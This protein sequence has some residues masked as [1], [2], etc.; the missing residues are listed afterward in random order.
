MAAVVRAVEALQA[1]GIEVVFVEL[2][3][4]PR[5]L[6]LYERGPAQHQES[7]DLLSAL[8]EDLE[9]P[10]I[11]TAGAYQDEDFVDYTHLTEEAA[12][13]FSVEVADALSALP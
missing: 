1:E 13:R 7:S 2:P 8:A 11:T 12:I 6:E 9:V 5:F 3:V 10:L 4:P